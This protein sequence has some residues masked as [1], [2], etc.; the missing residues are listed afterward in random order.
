IAALDEIAAR[1]A[2]RLQIVS[3]DAL[4]FDPRPMLGGERAKIVANLPYNIATALLVRWLA[5][6][7][8]P[9]WFDEMVLMF[10]RE[11]AE[12]IVADVG[13]PAYGP[14][15]VLHGSRPQARIQCGVAP[16]AVVPAQNVTSSVIPP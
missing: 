10:Q 6:E 4:E 2:G 7:P 16:S 11:V 12:R 8:W 13:E 5:A 14:L 9:P 15:A 3:A 1:Y